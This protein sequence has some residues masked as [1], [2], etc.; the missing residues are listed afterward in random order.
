[1]AIA[2]KPVPHPTD[3]GPISTDIIAERFIHGGTP[4]ISVGKKQNKEP[5]IIRFDPA[6]LAVIDRK[7]A[8]L[9][10]SRSAWVRM[11]VTQVLEGD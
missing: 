4:P 10:L 6:Q 11:V 9:G 1:M 2:K 8:G 3:I 5:I 7:A